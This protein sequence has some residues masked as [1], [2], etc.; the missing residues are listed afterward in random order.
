M[1]FGENIQGCDYPDVA[2]CSGVI[3]SPPPVLLSPPP[4]PPPPSQ[5]PQPPPNSPP[6]S[7]PAPRLPPPPFVTPPP[8]PPPPSPP[9]PFPPPPPPLDRNFTTGLDLDSTKAVERVASEKF[10][11]N[12]SRYQTVPD[13]SIPSSVDWSYLFGSFVREQLKCSELP[14]EDPFSPTLKL[15]FIY[16]MVFLS[17]LTF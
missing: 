16:L 9:P 10:Y 15:S 13:D 5:P 17:L 4:L 14:T 12:I 2:I 11:S 6:P 3:Y 8:F 1:I 7:P